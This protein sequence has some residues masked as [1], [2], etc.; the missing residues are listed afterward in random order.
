MEMPRDQCPQRR[1]E[2][3]IGLD[4]DVTPVIIFAFMLESRSAGICILSIG[5]FGR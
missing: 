1:S 2:Y 3:P 4:K 5:L